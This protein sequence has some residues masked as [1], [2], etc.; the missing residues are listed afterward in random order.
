MLEKALELQVRIGSAP[1]AAAVVAA[2]SWLAS[3]AGLA[4]DSPDPQIEIKSYRIDDWRLEP[5][6][7]LVIKT[8]DGRSYRA[9]LVQTCVGLAHTDRI[10]FLTRGARN[11]DKFAGIML[12]DGNRCYF[13]TL[14][15]VT[16]PADSR[17][18]GG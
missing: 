7:V 11:V 18:K 6:N 8:S 2:V 1:L 12:P 13:R 14:E 3:P 4:A 5:G 10:A 15:P 9:S 16:A 17:T